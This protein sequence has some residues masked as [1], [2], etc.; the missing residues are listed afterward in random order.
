MSDRI[1]GYCSHCLEKT[2]HRE[3]QWNSLRRNAYVCEGCNKP[4]YQCRLCGNFAKGGDFYDDE[5]CV[6][7]DPTS[8]D[9]F[10]KKKA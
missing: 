1:K 10:G 6:D 4:T 9:T 3:T 5:F 2:Y 7:H 8:D